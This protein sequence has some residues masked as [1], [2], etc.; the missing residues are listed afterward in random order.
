MR[1]L[2]PDFSVRDFSGFATLMGGQIVT[3]ALVIFIEVRDW[4]NGFAT[5]MRGKSMTFREDFSENL[6][7]YDRKS[8]VGDLE[9][10]RAITASHRLA[11]HRS[12]KA[13]NQVTRLNKTRRPSSQT[14]RKGPPLNSSVY[15]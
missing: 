1:I 12:G 14:C 11:A 6:A 2:D 7:V 3:N 9:K 4:P 13:I 10:D 8:R 15:D 5:P